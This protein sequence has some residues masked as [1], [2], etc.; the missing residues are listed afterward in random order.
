[1]IWLS[2]PAK[3]N[4]TLATALAK[5]QIDSYIQPAIRIIH[6]PETPSVNA[7]LQ[8]P[9]RFE[10][11]VF[12]SAEAALGVTT[13]LPDGDP[14][15]T[16]A[17]GEATANALP[18]R[19]RL[20]LPATPLSDS[21]SLLS[22]APL[23]SPQHVA[24]LGGADRS[25]PI[26]APFLCRTL[27]ARGATVLPVVCYRRYYLPA[28]A[29]LSSLGQH[30]HIHG[31]VAYSTETLTAMLRMTQPDNQ[32]LRQ[33]PLFVIHPR[34]KENALHYGFQQVHLAPHHSIAAT[35]AATLQK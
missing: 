35:I 15:P 14:L 9:E 31:A 24:V 4:Q 11:S 20:L 28:D 32:W 19:C 10:V 6:T 33:H 1:M 3:K 16:L 5:R 7:Y 23:T 17:I 34:I 13:R 22:L 25:H 29:T 21:R 30:G 12:I 2:R 18:H 8:Q 27:K 26:P